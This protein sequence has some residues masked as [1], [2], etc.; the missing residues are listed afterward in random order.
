MRKSSDSVMTLFR[1]FFSCS[2][3]GS[4]LETGIRDRNKILNSSMARGTKS[5]DLKLK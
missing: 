4:W 5:I 1:L 3:L 2:S